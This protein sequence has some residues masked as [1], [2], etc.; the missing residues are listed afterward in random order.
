MWNS[1]CF[2]VNY[3]VWC[4]SSFCFFLSMKIS[5]SL[6]FLLLKQ[7][8]FPFCIFTHQNTYNFTAVLSFLSESLDNNQCRAN[9]EV[10]KKNLQ[11]KVPYKKTV[12]LKKVNMSTTRRRA[13]K[14][15][16][17]MPSQIK[18]CRELGTPALILDQWGFEVNGIPGSRQKQLQSSWEKS[19]L[20]LNL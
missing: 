20:H 10:T 13:E 11:Q 7:T 18:D 9:S 15:R 4:D 3:N 2:K 17:E 1:I 8:S 19:I 6:N 16:G 14:K 5:H 12:H